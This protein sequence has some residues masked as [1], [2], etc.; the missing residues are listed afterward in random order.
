MIVIAMMAGILVA[1]QY[2]GYSPPSTGSYQGQSSEGLNTAP[3]VQLEQKCFDKAIAETEGAAH[4]VRQKRYDACLALHDA[5]VKHATAKLDPKEAADAKRDLDRA[6]LV[7]E[8][9][10]AAR[11]KIVMPVGTK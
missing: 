7:V 1:A 11:M 10:Y 8:K 2:G 6:L 3:Y 9:K 5:M 4:D